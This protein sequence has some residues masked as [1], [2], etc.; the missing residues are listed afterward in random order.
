MTE[1][2]I[3][4]IPKLLFGELTSIPTTLAANRVYRSSHPEVFCKKGVLKTSAKT[5]VLEYLF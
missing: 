3:V 2:N 5:P 4:L 1:F